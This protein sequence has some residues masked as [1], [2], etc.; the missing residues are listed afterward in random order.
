M[1]I[2]I[3]IAMILVGRDRHDIW[4]QLL[5]GAFIAYAFAVLW[6]ARRSKQH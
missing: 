1:L 5:G 4:S 6:A 3:G 2:L